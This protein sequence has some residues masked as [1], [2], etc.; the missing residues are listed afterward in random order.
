MWRQASKI[1]KSFTVAPRY[2]YS[3]HPTPHIWIISGIVYMGEK[4]LSDKSSTSYCPNL[5]EIQNR[6]WNVPH[7]LEWKRGES[8]KNSGQNKNVRREREDDDQL[9][10]KKIYIAIFERIFSTT[11]RT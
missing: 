5:D 8:D 11:Y 7:A 2:Q 9:L 6:L 3:S 1:N 10:F 4:A